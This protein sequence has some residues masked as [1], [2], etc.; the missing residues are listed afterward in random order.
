[1]QQKETHGN[2]SKIAYNSDANLEKQMVSI[3]NSLCQNSSTVVQNYLRNVET[4]TSFVILELLVDI[5]GSCIDK[6]KE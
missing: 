4:K 5:L 2:Y 3:I 1:L 6:V